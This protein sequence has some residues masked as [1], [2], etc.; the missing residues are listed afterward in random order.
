M[1][2]GLEVG[3]HGLQFKVGKGRS[4]FV[5]GIQQCAIADIYANVTAK[6]AFVSQGVEQQGTGQGSCR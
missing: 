5:L 6:G 1:Q 3:C 2:L 4:Q